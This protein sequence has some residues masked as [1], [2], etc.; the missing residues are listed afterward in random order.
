M[1]NRKTMNYNIAISLIVATASEALIYATN[2]P[3]ENFS[4]EK[5]PTRILKQLLPEIIQMGGSK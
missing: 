5:K 2:S 4:Y 1:E 3:L